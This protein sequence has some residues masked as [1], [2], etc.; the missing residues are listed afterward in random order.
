MTAIRT[1]RRA[2]ISVDFGALS[3]RAVVA[4]D[5]GATLGSAVHDALDAE[6]ATLHD[7][8]GRGGNDV[9][10]RLKTTQ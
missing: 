2:V 8:F 3:V 7:H 10:H 6:Y 9:M 4:V 1:G 5:D